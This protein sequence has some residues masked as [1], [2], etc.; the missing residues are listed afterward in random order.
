MTAPLLSLQQAHLVHLAFEWMAM[1]I[2]FQLYRRQ[3]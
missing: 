2:G 3:R 1:T